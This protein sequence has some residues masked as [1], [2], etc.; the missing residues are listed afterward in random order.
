MFEKVI[1][2]LLKPSTIFCRHTWIRKL[3]EEN[4]RHHLECMKCFKQTPGI[5]LTPR[6]PHSLY[7]K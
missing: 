3:D 4:F 1:H 7:R 6:A 5:D 2:W